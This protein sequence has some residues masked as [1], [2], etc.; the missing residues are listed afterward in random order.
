MADEIKKRFPMLNTMIACVSILV[1][2][3]MTSHDGNELTFQV[4]VNIIY[5]FYFY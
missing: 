1:P 5:L 4:I 2:R 3:K